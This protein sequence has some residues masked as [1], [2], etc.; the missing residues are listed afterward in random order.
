MNCKAELRALCGKSGHMDFTSTDN[1]LYL[2]DSFY[3]GLDGP[4]RLEQACQQLSSP[5]VG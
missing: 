2:N 3:Q 1:I 5:L 4:Q